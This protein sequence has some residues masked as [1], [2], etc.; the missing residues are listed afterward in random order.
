MGGY[1]T[2]PQNVSIDGK[3]ELMKKKS[4]IA[5]F[6]AEKSEIIKA[7]KIRKNPKMS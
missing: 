4:E 7:E 6:F 1:T 5:G 3:N 2:T